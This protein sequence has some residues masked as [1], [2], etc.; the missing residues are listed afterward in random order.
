[1]NT[2]NVNTVLCRYERGLLD[3]DVSRVFSESPAVHQFRDKNAL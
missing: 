2:Y 1:M 3:A